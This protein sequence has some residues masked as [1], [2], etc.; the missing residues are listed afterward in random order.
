MKCLLTQLLLIGNRTSM[1]GAWF[2]SLPVRLSTVSY[3][4]PNWR[5]WRN[6]QK[7]FFWYDES[8]V[9]PRHQKSIICFV[10]DLQKVML[11]FD[12]PK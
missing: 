7:L 10:S 11:H 3:V 4:E 1:E 9:L 2:R 6:Q 5:I 8:R 12:C